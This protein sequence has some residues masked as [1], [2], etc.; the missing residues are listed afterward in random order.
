VEC[1]LQICKAYCLTP[2]SKKSCFFLKH[3]K[4]VGIDVLPDGDC[5]AMSEHQLLDHWPTP[6]FV[7][8]AASFTGFV[9]FYS[10]HIPYLEVHTKPLREIIQHEYTS[11]IGDLWTPTAA[12]AFD[13]LCQ[14]N[15]CNL[16]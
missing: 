9:Q 5:P 3:F 12:A 14:C 15:L 16:A 11:G 10:I 4:F 13:K 2:S 6:E 8:N 7:C 1:Q